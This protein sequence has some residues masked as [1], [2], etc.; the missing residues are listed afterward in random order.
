[1]TQAGR[2]SSGL[3]MKAH[4]LKVPLDYS[5]PDGATIDVFFR[6]VNDIQRAGKEK[7]PWLLYLQ[8]K[9]YLNCGKLH[10]TRHQTK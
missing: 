7:Q 8:G 6:I 4:T 3:I 5:K 1:M 10:W 9:S 2:A